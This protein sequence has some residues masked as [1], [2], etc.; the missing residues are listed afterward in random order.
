MQQD[1]FAGAIIALDQLEKTL[2]SGVC[3]M[4]K[5]KS[6]NEQVAVMDEKVWVANEAG[7]GN[8]DI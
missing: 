2:A 7:L 5:G 3:E 4:D 8:I 6:G 1:N